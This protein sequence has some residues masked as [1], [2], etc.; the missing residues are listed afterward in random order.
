MRQFFIA[1]KSDGDVGVA[2][3]EG[4][5]HGKNF[6]ETECVSAENSRLGYFLYFNF[7]QATAI[8]CIAFFKNSS[9][10]A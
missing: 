3:V 8:R 10:A 2:D 4:E 7:E 6:V 9:L 5:E 1:E